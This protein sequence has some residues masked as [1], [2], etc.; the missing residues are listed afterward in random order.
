MAA[1]A[2]SKFFKS[3]T[4]KNVAEYVVKSG[5]EGLEE[6]IAGYLQAHAKK[7]TFKTEEDF[8]KILEDEN[9]FEQFVVGSLVSGIAQGGG[10]IQSNMQGRDLVTNN[11]QNEQAVID[12]VYEDRIAEEEKNGNKVSNKRKNEI[13]DEVVS[14]M[15]RGYISTDT[16]EEVLGG[17][18]YKAYKD[19]VA[20]EDA[21]EVGRRIGREE[22]V[23]VGI[24]SGAAAWAAIEL[25]KRPENE[26]KTIVVLLPD[27]GDRYLSTA[28][29]E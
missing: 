5:F 22:G 16:I 24:S 13:L 28:L 21:F 19:T 25:A 2:V 9:L 17:D 11:T 23:L 1:K 27:T 29:F 7:G 18:D 4:G 6:V 15:E 14:D 20:N 26:G 12:K 10:V 8:A 3:Q